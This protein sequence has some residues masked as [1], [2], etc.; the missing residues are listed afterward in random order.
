MQWKMYSSMF[1]NADML[2]WVFKS[3][4]NAECNKIRKIILKFSL[5]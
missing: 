1:L 3:K 2:F 4:Y 5:F